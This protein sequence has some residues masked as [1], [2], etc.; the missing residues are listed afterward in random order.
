MESCSKI[1]EFSW[2]EK[3]LHDKLLLVWCASVCMPLVLLGLLD[4][5]HDNIVYHSTRLKYLFS[6]FGK[7]L[8]QI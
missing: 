7:T 1:Q 2:N 3:V 8:R 5:V 4:G 6:L